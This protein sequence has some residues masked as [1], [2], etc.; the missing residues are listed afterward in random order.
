MPFWIQNSRV[1]RVIIPNGGRSRR[2]AKHDII[3]IRRVSRNRA[4]AGGG[5]RL[6]CR[7]ASHR[8]RR[9]RRCGLLRESYA[10]RCRAGRSRR[11]YFH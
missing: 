7:R 11:Q 1:F 9:R 2:R 6:S 8:V 4:G 5:R 10:K 3:R